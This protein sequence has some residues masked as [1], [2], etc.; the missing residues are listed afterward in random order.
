MDIKPTERFSN[1]A[2][3]YAKYRPSFSTAVFDTFRDKCGL[4]EK[5]VVAD[6]GS[7]T[8][9]FSE[10]FLQ[11]GNLVYGVEPNTPM[12]L[13]GEQYLRHYSNFRSVAATAEQTMLP[14]RS[15]DFVVAGQAAHW[16]DLDQARQEF[17]RILKPNGHIALC[18]NSPENKASPFMKAKQALIRRFT[19][20]PPDSKTHS[21]R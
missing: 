13:A 9:L 14:D 16:F 15:V 21:R 2:E 3:N 20:D 5:A 6:I 11:H 17:V 4:T 10:L 7:G 18:R 19:L 8:G 12:R 1:R